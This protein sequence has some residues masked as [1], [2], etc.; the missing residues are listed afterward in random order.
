M[1]KIES[2]GEILPRVMNQI[3]ERILDQEFTP[4]R[5]IMVDQIDALL[6]EWE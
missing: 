5:S 3:K 2:V 6:D 1:Q 4:E